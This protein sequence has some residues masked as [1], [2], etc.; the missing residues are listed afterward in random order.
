MQRKIYAEKEVSG[1]KICVKK[2]Y[3]QRKGYVWRKEEDRVKKRSVQ[4]KKRSVQKKL[5]I[6][7]NRPQLNSV[8]IDSWHDRSKK[9]R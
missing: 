2:R 9:K 5:F 7:N 8:S 4:K 3:V 1:G 6:Y